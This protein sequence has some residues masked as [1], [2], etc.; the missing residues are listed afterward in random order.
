MVVCGRGDQ[1]RV[2][3]SEKKNEMPKVF[4]MSEWSCP[5]IQFQHLHMHGCR[6][7]HSH[8]LTGTICPQSP[9]MVAIERVML[10]LDSESAPTG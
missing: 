10:L 5:K 2:V 7:A 6:R 1:T 3:M 8:T 9:G 4:A